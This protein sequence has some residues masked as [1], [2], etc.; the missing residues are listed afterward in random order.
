MLII[1]IYV[2]KGVMLNGIVWEHIQNKKP[3][4]REKNTFA[5]FLSTKHESL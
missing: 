2:A 1:Q 3:D 5:K 4:P